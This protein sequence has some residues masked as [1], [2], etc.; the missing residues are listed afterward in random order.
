MTLKSQEDTHTILKAWPW[1]RLLSSLEDPSISPEYAE[2]SKFGFRTLSKA[3]WDA[4]KTEYIAYRARL[5]EEIASSAAAAEDPAP[6]RKTEAKRP[7][8]EAA[9]EPI[10]PKRVQPVEARSPEYPIGCLVFVRNVHP[11]TNKTTLRKLF[12]V[13]FTT[14][15]EPGSGIDYV[16]FSK[17]MDTVRLLVQ[18]TRN[19]NSLAGQCHLR[20][21]SPQHSQFLVDHFR[22]RP[23]IQSA[24]LDDKGT[25]PP[26]SAGATILLE[27]VPGKREEL[28]WEKVPAKVRYE[29]LRKA[30]QGGAGDVGLKTNGEVGG[31]RKRRKKDDT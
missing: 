31:K 10:I 26:N 27:I 7:L 5:V 18:F 8:P 3:E 1:N 29:A 2:A 6:S 20:L 15:E 11:E 4:L 14:P 30:G 13:A 9:V 28:Y 23:T 24:G 12:E 21:V 19:F 16:D 17:G 25:V 22:T